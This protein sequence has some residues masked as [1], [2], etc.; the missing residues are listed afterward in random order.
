MEKKGARLLYIRALF[1]LAALVLTFKA[2]DLQLLN[3]SFRRE[4]EAVAIEKY[5]KYPSRG[6]IYDRNG[7][8]LVHNNPMY[9][10]LVTYN[11][12]SRDMDTALFFRLLGI[13]RKYFEE[14]LDKDWASRRFSKSVP[15]VFLC[16]I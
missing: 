10:L 6:M 15:F 14:T 9:D 5:V 1:I 16:K 3:Q 4:A 11:Q 2:L 12:V 8:L 7:E 13:E